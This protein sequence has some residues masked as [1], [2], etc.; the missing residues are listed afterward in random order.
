MGYLDFLSSSA[1]ERGSILCFGL[2]PSLSQI[3]QLPDSDAEKRIVSFFSQII[4]ASLEENKS[5]S[6]IKP[7]YAHFSQYG[8]EGLRALKTII[9]RYKGRIPVILDAKRGDVGSSSQAY[10]SEIFGFWNADAVTL[11]PYM[12]KDSLLPFFEHCKRGRGAYVLCRTSNPGSSDFQSLQ[13]YDGKPLFINVAKQLV[14]WHVDGVGAVLGATYLEQLEAALWVFH[15]SGK[16]FPL[17]MPGVGAQG[18]SASDTAKA[19]R[20]IW[21]QALK[22]HR[23]SS[24]RAIS[25]AYIE[26]KTDD[27]VGA[28]LEKI[29]QLNSQIGSL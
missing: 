20:S 27:F 13:L 19:L 6:A 4:D 25:Y 16:K 5:I 10:A 2:D 9:E 1:H 11:S 22:L 18:A 7:N 17:L 14:Q 24:S 21:P 23:I 29:R 3:P 28:A 26:A 12:G 15:D 8:F